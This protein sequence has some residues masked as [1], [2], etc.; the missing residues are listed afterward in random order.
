M[1]NV[2]SY[3]IVSQSFSD[4]SIWDFTQCSN[5]NAADPDKGCCQKSFDGWSKN[6]TISWTPEPWTTTTWKPPPVPPHDCPQ[7]CPRFANTLSM[8]Y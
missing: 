5:I 3:Y 6:M 1:L 2:E 4:Y 8:I 7:N